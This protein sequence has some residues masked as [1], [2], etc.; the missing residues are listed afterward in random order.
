[1]G[2]FNKRKKNHTVTCQRKGSHNPKEKNLQKH[3]V[4]WVVFI[5]FMLLLKKLV[6]LAAV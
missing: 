5:F 3:L 1:M 2:F 4:L 6:S